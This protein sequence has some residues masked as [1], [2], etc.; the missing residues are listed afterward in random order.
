[1]D[2]AIAMADVVIE[3]L[4]GGGAGDDE[5]FLH[6]H[7]DLG[8]IEGVAQVIAVGAEFVADG[9]EEQLHPRQVSRVVSVRGVWQGVH[10]AVVHPAHNGA[11]G[12]EMNL[13]HGVD[14]DPSPWLLAA[15]E[16]LMYGVYISRR[17]IHRTQIYLSSEE[18]QGLQAL[19][20]QVG[21]YQSD[22]IRAAI[23]GFLERHR[24]SER[25][26]RLRRARGLWSDW[27]DTPRLP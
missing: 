4:Q 22:L 16:C 15:G 26:S 19:A 23:D 6:L 8:A 10:R 27:E 2:H 9:G 17:S 21:R 18:R 3:H 1:V 24:P 7:G 25:L 11:C 20:R 12:G 13:F 14:C 5:V